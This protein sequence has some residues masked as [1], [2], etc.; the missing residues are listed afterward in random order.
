MILAI[1]WFVLGWCA[2]KLWTAT[3]IFRHGCSIHI[4]SEP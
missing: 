3:A 2:C 1:M 4:H